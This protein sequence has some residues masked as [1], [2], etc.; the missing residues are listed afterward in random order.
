M[1][2]NVGQN[3][4]YLNT[5]IPGTGLYDRIKIGGTKM[6]GNRDIEALWNMA[7]TD[8]V[9]A[10]LF[11]DSFVPP[12]KVFGGI[13][14]F[15]LFI[16]GLPSAVIGLL[17]TVAVLVMPTSPEKFQLL[18]GLIS[19]AVIGILFYSVH[20]NNHRKAKKN[21]DALIQHAYKKYAEYQE[22]KRQYTEAQQKI[23]D[24]KLN[25]IHNNELFDGARVF[26]I[27]NNNIIA[28]SKQRCIA[29][30][31]EKE[32]D[33]MKVL[34]VEHITKITQEIKAGDCYAHIFTDD[35]ENNVYDLFIGT[36]H[37]QEETEEV[38]KLYNEIKG[39]YTTL[40]NT[41]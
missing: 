22:A 4:A 38:R 28:F 16:I 23:L 2:L 9:R 34:G 1:S 13:P 5:G 36:A 15:F 19:S 24:A 31:T 35:F 25:A 8:D 6:L 12:Y 27:N 32:A 33:T 40:K 20:F 11:Q 30:F 37:G 18:T 7:A 14:S 17:G 29:L 41:K 39:L 21:R 3:G 26:T 10:G